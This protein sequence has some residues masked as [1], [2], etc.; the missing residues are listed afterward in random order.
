MDY[1]RKVNASAQL[2]THATQ[3]GHAQFARPIFMD[4]RAPCSARD[5][6]EMHPVVGSVHAAT[7]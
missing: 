7:G 4:P 6:L 5:W 1:A 3:P 2:D